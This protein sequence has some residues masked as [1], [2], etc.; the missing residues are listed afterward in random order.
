MCERHSTKLRGA[1]EFADCAAAD[2]AISAWTD[3]SGASM[4]G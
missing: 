4:A 1:G 3:S 2:R